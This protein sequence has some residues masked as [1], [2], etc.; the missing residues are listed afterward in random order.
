[1]KQ[2]KPNYG[3]CL[4]VYLP[5]LA[6]MQRRRTAG[7]FYLP[8]GAKYFGSRDTLAAAAKSRYDLGRPFRNSVSHL[9]LLPKR[10]SD[11]IV[12]RQCI[13][14]RLRFSD[15]GKLRRRRKAFEGRREDGL[16]VRGAIG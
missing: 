15:L 6:Q 4:V 5:G 16:G 10:L 9:L 3:G 2:G 1:M 11:P 12:F 7:K 14:Q 8:F 13:E